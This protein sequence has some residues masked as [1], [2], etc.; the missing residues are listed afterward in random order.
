MSDWKK[1]KHDEVMIPVFILCHRKTT[2]NLL[3]DNLCCEIRMPSGNKNR[4][5]RRPFFARSIRNSIDSMS[6]IIALTLLLAGGA[7]ILLIPIPI[8]TTVV[9][10]QEEDNNTTIAGRA[11][12]TND[13]TRTS[14]IPSSSSSGLELSAQPIWDEEVRTTAIIPINETHSIAEFEGNGTMTAPVTGEIINMTNNGT[15][16]G[17]LMPEANDTVISYG[18]ENVFSLDDGDTSAIT[19]FEIVRYD[20]TTFQGKGLAIAVFDRNAT[21]SLA[22][23]NGMLVVGTHVEDPITQ[24]VTIRLWEWETGIPLPRIIATMEESV[25]SSMNTTT[26]T[27]VIDNNAMGVTEG[28]QQQQQQQQQQ[29]Y[30]L[31][32]TNTVAG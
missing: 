29:N 12:T 16:I 27:G 5:S 17:S 14:A 24:T 19:F 7:S 3:N 13:T 32:T 10:A 2:S 1:E 20:P 22:P 11:T 26:P 21:G 8:I 28:E 9:F 31:N 25:P 6:I 23:F 4:K 30:S 15:A 18:R